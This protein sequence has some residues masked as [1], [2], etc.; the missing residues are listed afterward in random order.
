MCKK[1]TQQIT[2]ILTT[3]QLLFLKIPSQD[4]LIKGLKIKMQIYAQIL[5]TL[6]S[7]YKSTRKLLNLQSLEN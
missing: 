7:F 4:C 6:I 1:Q 2:E 3:N 5:Q